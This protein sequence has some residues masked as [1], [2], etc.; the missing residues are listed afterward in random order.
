MWPGC[1]LKHFK[2]RFEAECVVALQAAY[3]DSPLLYLP[4]EKEN[5]GVRNFQLA[6]TY[7]QPGSP[8]SRQEAGVMS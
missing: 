6:D 5:S 1:S 8:Q 3:T 4:I 2:A 7:K